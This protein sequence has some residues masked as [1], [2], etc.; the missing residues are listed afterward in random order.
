MGSK[1]KKA[2]EEPALEFSLEDE[3]DT[4]TARV[5]DYL[6]AM[7]A[8]LDAGYN[9]KGRDTLDALDTLCASALEI[10]RRQLDDCSRQYAEMNKRH[11]S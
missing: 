5:K 6:V 4:Q 8:L 9:D 3:W 7:R 11:E 1:P 10:V 2:V